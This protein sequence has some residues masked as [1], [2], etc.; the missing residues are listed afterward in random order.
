M[1]VR[2]L[3][4]N[5]LFALER[6]LHFASNAVSSSAQQGFQPARYSD[7]LPKLST[8]NTN[9]RFLHG[10]PPKIDRDERRN[11]TKILDLAVSGNL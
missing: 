7:C 5:W 3:T 11:S 6:G 4:E 9:K 1:I 8:I 2:A 10:S